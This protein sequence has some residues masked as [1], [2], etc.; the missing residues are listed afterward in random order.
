VKDADNLSLRE[1]VKPMYYLP[2]EQNYQPAAQIRSVCFFIRSQVDLATLERAARTTVHNLDSNLPV[3]DVRSMAARVDETIYADRLSAI[4]AVAFGILAMLL[5][6]VGLYGVV[7]Y[8]VAKRTVE[9]GIRLALGASPGQVLALVMQEVVRL[10]AV[11]VLVGVPVAYALT[12]LMTS[13]LYEVAPGSAGIFGASVAIIAVLAALAG[14]IPA[15]RA[16][17]I[18]PKQAL[19]Y[20]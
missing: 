9:L 16:S 19:R 8:S 11:G 6:G 20:E 13:Q 1:T 15:V 7:A 12:R 18:D 4:L 5:A 2:L 10:V 3:F 17:T 14:L